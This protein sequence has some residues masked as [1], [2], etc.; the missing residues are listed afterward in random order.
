MVP[1]NTNS[2]FDY[3]KLF[4]DIEIMEKFVESTNSYARAKNID[5]WQDVDV[6]VLWKFF[7]VIFYMGIAQLPSRD[8][9]WR[10]ECKYNSAFLSKIM[11]RNQF[12]R[13]FDAFHYE[14]THEVNEEDRKKEE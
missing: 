13:I 14:K 10:Q 3:F 7:A 9:Y 11:S 5:S 2:E 12:N 6:N 4:W 1:A 8:M